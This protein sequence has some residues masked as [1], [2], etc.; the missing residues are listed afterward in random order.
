MVKGPWAGG[1]YTLRSSGTVET[2]TRRVGMYQ[3]PIGL[4]GQIGVE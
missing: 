1:V 2:C 4:R 3:T